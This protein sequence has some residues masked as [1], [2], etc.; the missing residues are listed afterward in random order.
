MYARI[1][2]LIIVVLFATGA[3]AESEIDEYQRIL[4]EINSLIARMTD[5]LVPLEKSQI[6]ESLPR[7]KSNGTDVELC[8]DVARAEAIVRRLRELQA[9][10]VLANKEP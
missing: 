3:W 1:V 6:P 10:N 8:A 4:G 2:T 7:R 9:N 5:N